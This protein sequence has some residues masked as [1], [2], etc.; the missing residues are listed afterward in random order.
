M[1]N[2]DRIKFF[3]YPFTILGA[4][5]YSAYSSIIGVEHEEGSSEYLF[6]MVGLFCLS[7][8]FV[9]RDLFTYS[10]RVNKKVLLIP[11]FFSLCYFFET[12]FES[13]ILEWTKKSF[14]FHLFFSL[15]ALMSASILASTHQ[16]E[17]I[18]KNMDII[19]L[20]LAI[21]MIAIL[22]KMLLMGTI[23]NGYNKISYQSALAFGYLYYGL[24]SKREDRYYIFKTK[25]YRIACIAMCTLLALTSLASGGRG[26]VVLLFVQIAIISLIY[27]SRRNIFRVFFLFVPL[28]VAFVMIIAS[29]LNDSAFASVLEIGMDRAFSYISENGIDMS[30]TSGRDEAYELALANI[31]LNPWTGYGIFHTIGKF[32]YPHNIFLEMLEQGGVLYLFVWLI[33]ILKSLKRGWYMLKCDNNLNFL[34]P[35]ML[36]PCIMLLFSGSYLMNA[37]FWFSICFCL[38]YP[39]K[40]LLISKSQIYGKRIII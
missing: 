18:Y 35:L 34:I 30:Q 19:M 16:V 1:N 2:L 9:I 27:V 6:F 33:I 22:P 26:G 32:G 31:Q 3:L 36:Y 11:I 29:L 20:I 13:P 38:I 10:N 40:Y 25:I 39:K 12:S 17:K 28:L 23:I 4:E 37:T 8:L 5:M 14:Y 24:L 21:G 7:M 15:P